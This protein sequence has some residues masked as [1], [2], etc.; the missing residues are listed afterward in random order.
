MAKANH[1]NSMSMGKTPRYLLFTY[2]NVP[3]THS[4]ERFYCFR[5]VFI[6]PPLSPQC[7]VVMIY[8][9]NLESINCCFCAA[10]TQNIGYISYFIYFPYAHRYKNTRTKN[11][12]L[13]I[14]Y[15]Y[16]SKISLQVRYTNKAM[17]E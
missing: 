1:D 12:H 5:N 3:T 11:N 9:D 7:C 10:S 8:K 2:L 4:L 16:F 6:F 14:F 13:L 15:L 17:Q